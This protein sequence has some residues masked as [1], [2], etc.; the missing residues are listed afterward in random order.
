MARTFRALA[1]GLGVA[2]LAALAPSS[3]RAAGPPDATQTFDA[4]LACAFPLQLDIYGFVQVNRAFPPGSDDPT[5]FLGAG[6]GSDLVFTNLSTGKTSRLKGN[7]SATWSV[8][9]GDGTARVT[10]TGHNVNIY[11]PSDS[12]AGPSTYLIVGREVIDVDLATSHFTRVSRT[13]SVTDI[14]ANLT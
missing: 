5:R 4:G 8:L 3:A 10:V 2:A 11:F 9:N 13:G 14:C 1:A 7:G 12:P 6:K